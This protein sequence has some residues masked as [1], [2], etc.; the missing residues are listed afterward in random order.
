MYLFRKTFEVYIK[1]LQLLCTSIFLY[2]ANRKK[3]LG[4]SSGFEDH[5]H[6]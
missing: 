1:I 4:Q 3:N 5:N 2:L 6:S